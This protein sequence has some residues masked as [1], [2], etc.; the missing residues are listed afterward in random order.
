MTIMN[1]KRT[2]R[3]LGHRTL[4]DGSRGFEFSFAWSGMETK[5]ITIEAPLELFKGPNQIAIQEAAAICYETLKAVEENDSEG[6][7]KRFKLSSADIAL[8]RKV[9]E[10][11]R[12]WR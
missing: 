11:Q 8:H 4:A 10:N 6:P 3:Y 12:R 2:I 9:T 1:N 5:L 7:P